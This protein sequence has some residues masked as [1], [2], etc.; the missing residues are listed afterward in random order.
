MLKSTLNKSFAVMGAAFTMGTMFATDAHATTTSGTGSFNGVAQ[1]IVSGI[2]SLP[3]FIT[4]LSYMMGLI[5]SVLGILKIKDHVENPGQHPLAHG[6]TRLAVGG[7]LFA[8][9]VITNA[10]QD[11]IGSDSAIDA[12]KLNKVKFETN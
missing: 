7:A 10:M 3:G 5:F 8:L 11:L 4:A 9:P 6:A 1:N 2:S 12:A